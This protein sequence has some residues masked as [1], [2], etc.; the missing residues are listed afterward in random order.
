MT[1][2]PAL[3]ARALVRDLGDEV[4]TRIL[5]GLD[6]AI[7]PGEF[8]SVTGPSGSGKSTLLY[9]LGALDR[10][11]SGEVL[12]EGV[13]T[14]GLDD[15]A[16]GVLRGERLGF[17]FQFHFLLPEFTSL[18]NVLIPMLRRRDLAAAEAR[19]RATAALTSLGIGEL[20]DR[21]PTQL[22]GGQ[23][24]RVSIARAIAHGPRILLADEPTGNLDTTAGAAVLAIFERLA[25][26]GM[27]VVM[28]T[29]EPSY[30]ARAGR[31]LRLRDGRLVDAIIRAPASA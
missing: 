8:V 12:I 25:A 23:Q 13:A 28:V 10:P 22:S 6:L 7:A 30:A 20:I 16:R 9:L 1:A 11:T 2:V 29:H 21:R 4:R 26:D 31:E 14:S 5:H 24:Q 19:R 15:R 3:E 27:T 17:V 18:E